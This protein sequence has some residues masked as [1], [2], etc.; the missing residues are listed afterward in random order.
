MEAKKNKI[1]INCE[2]A[3]HICNKSQHKEATF[4]DKIRLN[5]RLI[6]CHITRE[7]VKKNSKL[8]K[9]VNDKNV[10]CMD[11]KEKDQLKQ[12]FKKELQN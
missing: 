4:W 7:Y 6:Y 2:E 1:L 11:K 10:V 5:I 9:L 8:T 3:M 12:E